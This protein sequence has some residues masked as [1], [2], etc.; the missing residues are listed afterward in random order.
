MKKTF[1]VQCGNWCLRLNIN[2]KD[3][4]TKHDAY[5]EIATRSLEA[6]FGMKEF[7]DA[8]DDF[9]AILTEDGANAL[10]LDDD[11]ELPIPTFTTDTYV[12]S[13]KNDEPHKLVATLKTSE[14]FANAAQFDNFGY[15][16]EAEKLES[17][18]KKKK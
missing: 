18:N 3:F 6:V 8:D 7:D 17:K 4:E 16:L 12:L 15:A 10:D 11:A 13:S 1:F 14:L 9:Y 2:L 5:V